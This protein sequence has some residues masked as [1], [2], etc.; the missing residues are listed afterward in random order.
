MR[1]KIKR[2]IVRVSLLAGLVTAL[3]ASGVLFLEAVLP[4]TDLAQKNHETLDRI[5]CGDLQQSIH[6]GKPRSC[7]VSGIYNASPFDTSDFVLTKDTYFLLLSSPDLPGF[8][9]NTVDIDFVRQLRKPTSK[10]LPDGGMWRLYSHQAEVK[11]RSVEVIVGY[12]EWAPWVFAK[13]RHTSRL[14][15]QLKNEAIRIASGLYVEGSAI[16]AEKI[17]TKVM[18]AVV[19]GDSGRVIRWDEDVP[20]KLRL[21]KAPP[22][23]LSMYKEHSKLYVVRTDV[24]EFLIAISLHEIGD[25]WW[26]ATYLVATFA[27]GAVV[28]YVSLMRSPWLRA[29]IR[30]KGG[31]RVT[32]QEALRTGEGR[33]V[34]FKRDF[35]TDSVLK[36]ITAFANS[37]DGTIFIGIDDHGKIVGLPMETLESRGKF[38]ERIL[39]LVGSRIRPRADVYIDYESAEG[40][41]VARV[42]VPRGEEQLY[43]LDGRVYERVDNENVIAEPDRVKRLMEQFA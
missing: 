43:Y 13:L 3:V 4:F 7:D 37:G 34:E 6:A 27:V 33:G 42:F 8:W 17:R 19:Y 12:T 22:S 9:V 15:Q 32:L 35:T 18:F 28:V 1:R 24:N 5:H 16:R 21:A 36:A 39:N 30:P 29:I 38:Q 20:L 25:L 26:L 14:D 40:I 11:G 41:I 23:G 2:R 10:E 31:A